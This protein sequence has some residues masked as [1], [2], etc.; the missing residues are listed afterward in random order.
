MGIEWQE[1]ES[2]PINNEERSVRIHRIIRDI[3]RRQDADTAEDDQAIERQHPELMPELGQQLRMLRSIQAAGRSAKQRSS[4]SEALNG[5]PPNFEEDLR[6]LSEAL[7]K[8]TIL[9][10]VN[11]GGQGVVYKAIQKSTQRMAAVKILIDGPLA[12]ERQRQRLAREAELISRLDHPNII[13][14]YESGYV[15]GRPYFAMEYVDGLPIGDYALLHS[16]SITEIVKLFIT[17][18]EAVSH[19]HQQGVIHRDLNPSNILVSLEGVPHVLDFG[20]A[21]DAWAPIAK[22][23]GSHITISGQVVGTLPYLS[24]EQ[25]GADDGNVDVR[26]DIYS[27]GIVLYLLLT[28]DFPYP[29][30]GSVQEVRSHIVGRDARPLRKAFSPDAAVGCSGAVIRDLEVIL[31]KALSKEKAARYQSAVA[32]A[33]DLKRCLTGEPVEARAG[34]H[35]YLLMRTFRKYRAAVA[36]VSFFLLMAGAWAIN[37]SMLWLE[38]SKQRDTAQAT[39]RLAFAT[40]D[41]VINEVDDAI[42]PLAGGMEARNWLLKSVIAERL[43][44]MRP[45]VESDETMQSLRAA[46]DE[47]MGDIAYAEGRHADAKQ[48]YSECLEI[49]EATL[50]RTEPS[51]DSLLELARAH[52][53]LAQVSDE[54]TM[55]FE[56]AIEIGQRVVKES[57]GNAD[58]EYALC[59]SLTEYGRFLFLAGR[60]EQ[61]ADRINEALQVAEPQAQA[62]DHE[63]RWAALLAEVFEW[64]GEINQKLGRDLRFI[65]SFDKSLHIRRELSDSRPADAHRRHQVVIAGLKLSRVLIDN[66]SLEEAQNVLKQAISIGEYLVSIDPTIAVWQRDLFAAHYLQAEVY[67]TKNDTTNAHAAVDAALGL[68]ENLMNLASES[69]DWLVTLAYAYTLRGRLSLEIKKPAEAIIDMKAALNIRQ[70]LVEDDPNNYS[71][72]SQLDVSHTWVGICSRCLGD[73]DGAFEHYSQA[74]QIAS[75]L[76]AKQPEVLQRIL[77]LIRTETNLGIGHCQFDTPEHDRRASEL[78]H[79]AADSLEALKNSGK[80]TVTSD[81]YQNAKAEIDNCLNSLNERACRSTQ[82]APHTLTGDQ[83]EPAPFLPSP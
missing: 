60:Y 77:D 32:L 3:V 67:W 72:L 49:R 61:A 81:T 57:T 48:N 40:L 23:D 31:Q 13:T 80:L 2:G 47:K 27:L 68:A 37:A 14:L 65:D 15:R 55:H 63:E 59:K 12:T 83:H 69:P 7:P 64:D 5:P 75:A 24:P 62:T 6:F 54:A 73:R 52:R 1:H 76:Y 29:I 35:F 18:C 50:S 74:H 30:D 58:A 78:V 43:K 19:A 25:A 28:G 17:V 71:A 41:D 45:L 36:I 42:A 33:Q 8:F 22:N 9:E 56:Q 10:R 20:L 39:A 26:S 82:S 66:N 4:L 53:K 21:L 46:L 79:Q 51:S 11:Y 34:S 38:A 16:L 44:E 70:R